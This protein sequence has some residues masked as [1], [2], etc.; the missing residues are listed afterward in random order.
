MTIQESILVLERSGINILATSRLFQTPAFPAGSGLDYVNAAALCESALP[1]SELLML[2]QEI[3]GMFGRQR[4]QRWGAR[5]LDIDLL[6]M[7]NQVLP[8]ISTYHEWR[9]L[10]L[11]EQQKR[12]PDELIL[13]H[14][15][16]QDRGFVLVPLADIAPNWVH[17]VLAKTVTTMLA[18]LPAQALAGIRPIMPKTGF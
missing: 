15:R 9:D 10:T 4:D 12:T 17:P 18:D 1:P 6:A 11:H 7:G 2:L 13:P 5:T 8:E 3:E 16:I 14:P